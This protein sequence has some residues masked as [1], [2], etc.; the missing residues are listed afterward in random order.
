M[1]QINLL[2]TAF[3]IGCFFTASA[4]DTI[5]NQNFE[6]WTPSGKPAP[7]DWSEPTGWTTSNP[8]TEFASAGVKRVQLPGTTTF[9]AEISTKNIFGQPVPGILINGDFTLSIADTAKF[10]LL[11]GTPMTTVKQK[12]WGLYNFAAAD[13]TDSATFV[14]AFKKFNTTTQEPDMVAVGNI[15][16]GSTGPGL[17]PFTV[18][19]QTLNGMTPDSVV[20]TIASTDNRNFQQGGVL[21]IDFVSFTKPLSVTTVEKSFKASVYPNPTREHMLVETDINAFNYRITDVTGKTVLSGTSAQA[22]TMVTLSNLSQGYYILNIEGENGFQS[23]PFIK[24]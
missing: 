22:S 10:P 2:F 21:T 1:K 5:V 11:G 16:L 19:I 7:F 4:Q 20:V 9:Q 6:Q 3:F 14:I 24:D 15:Y 18:D 8:L 13:T 17:H 12:A 23:L